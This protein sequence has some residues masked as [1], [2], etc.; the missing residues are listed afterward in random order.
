LNANKKV[1]TQALLFKTNHRKFNLPSL[2]TSFIEDAYDQIELLGF[3]LYSYFDLIDDVYQE[4]IKASEL[5][6]YINQNVLLYGALVNT[7]FH[8]T[9]NGK[10]IRFCTFVDCAGHYFDTV[11][12]SKVVDKYPIHGLG[13]YECYGKVTEEFDFCSLDIIWTKKMSLKRDP[14]SL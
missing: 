4:H 2:P 5:N 9:S 3:P 13:V 10:L 11:H 7:R 12:F 6:N 8:R 1:T 14:R